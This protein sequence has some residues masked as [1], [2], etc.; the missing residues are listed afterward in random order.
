[1]KFKE[2]MVVVPIIKHPMVYL[3][4]VLG[5]LA[6]LRTPILSVF[7]SPEMILMIYL[8][9]FLI[10][11][12]TFG[13]KEIGPF[14]NKGGGIINL[15]GIT[16]AVYVCGILVE[17]FA[18]YFL[19]ANDPQLLDQ[20]TFQLSWPFVLN[21]FARYSLVGIGEEIFKLCVFLIL[22]WVGVK[23]SKHKLGSCI[24]SVIVTSF[25][26]GLLHSNYNY[27][28]WLNI[29]LIIGAGALVYFYFLLK[30]QTIVPLMIAHGLQDFLVTMEHTGELT[31]I[32][33]LFLVGLILIWFI[34][35]F[36]FGVKVKTER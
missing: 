18:G 24:I 7:S 26:F 35:R 2:K 19:A 33:S 15:I 11:S 12:M 4:L 21:Q 34:A 1:M 31:G 25:F 14:Y 10:F 22:Y 8:G 27:D 30:Y 16:G 17:S 32:Y 3:G 20:Y 29:T 9:V 23:V 6:M 28:Q 5:F 36:G 13:F